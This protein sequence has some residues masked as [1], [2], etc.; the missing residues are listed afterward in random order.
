MTLLICAV[1]LM[2]CSSA[3]LAWRVVD[4]GREFCEV[5]REWLSVMLTF[6]AFL[7]LMTGIVV[8]FAAM[9]MLV[10]GKAG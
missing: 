4:C 5:W 8:A 9:G 3:L 10:E 2:L 1:A 7:A 6:W